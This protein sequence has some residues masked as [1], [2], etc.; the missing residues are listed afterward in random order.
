MSKDLVTG[1]IA[2][3]VV[4]AIGV[5]LLYLGGQGALP[6]G[7]GLFDMSND[8]V[9]AVVFIVLV[10]IAALLAF[11]YFRGQKQSG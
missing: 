10:V 8:G 9:R 3:L 11:V 1:L 5:L 4:A 2:T 6:L 7:F